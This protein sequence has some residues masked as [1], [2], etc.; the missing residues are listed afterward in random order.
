MQDIPPT[1]IPILDKKAKH[2]EFYEA[3]NFEGLSSLAN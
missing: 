2:E 3:S 1:Y